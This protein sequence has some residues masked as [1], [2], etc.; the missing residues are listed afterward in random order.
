MYENKWLLFVTIDCYLSEL[1][2]DYK[3]LILKSRITQ[4]SGVACL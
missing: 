3:K 1:I 4:G 2:Y